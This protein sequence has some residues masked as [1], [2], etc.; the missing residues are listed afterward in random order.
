MPAIT[1]TKRRYAASTNTESAGCTCG[2]LVEHAEDQ[3]LLGP[4]SDRDPADYED[5]TTGSGQD[6]QLSADQRGP[7][8]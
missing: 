2:C 1:R 7:P 5:N 4:R 6:D 3:Q 8:D